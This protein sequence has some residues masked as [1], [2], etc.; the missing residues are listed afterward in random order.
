MNEKKR[1]C[2]KLGLS[3]A[4]LHLLCHRF[5]GWAFNMSVCTLILMFLVSILTSPN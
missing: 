2:G 1:I 4:Y 3:S 5:D